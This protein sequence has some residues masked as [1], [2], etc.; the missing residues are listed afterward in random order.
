M[1]QVAADA[2]IA[3]EP[4]RTQLP[5]PVGAGKGPCVRVGVTVAVNVN[6]AGLLAVAGLVELVNVAVGAFLPTVTELDEAVLGTE[7]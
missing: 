3:P 4:D 2:F 5:V 1:L 7:R 6:V